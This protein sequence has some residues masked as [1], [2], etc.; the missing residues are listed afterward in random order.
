MIFN[1][2]HVSCSRRSQDMNNQ[3]Y[4]SLKLLCHPVHQW[5]LWWCTEEAGHCSPSRKQQRSR[6]WHVSSQRE[7]SSRRIPVRISLYRQWRIQNNC[8]KGRTPSPTPK[9]CGSTFRGCNFIP[10]VEFTPPQ[11]FVLIE[12]A[13]FL[14]SEVRRPIG[15]ANLKINKFQ[16]ER[17]LQSLSHTG[18]IFA[19]RR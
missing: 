10:L 5:M 18:V 17:N 2:N 6:V 14:L 4:S 7:G 9:A 1:R 11:F 8:K 19:A 15:G 16:N 13:F 12:M 3:K